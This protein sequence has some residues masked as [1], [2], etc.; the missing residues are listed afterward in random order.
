MALGT[1]LTIII[2]LLAIFI[3]FKVVKKIAKAVIYAASILISGKASQ[4][5][6]L[7]FCWRIRAIFW[8]AIQ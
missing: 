2:Y 1:I 6:E 4:S 7:L 5:R 8:Q 3:I